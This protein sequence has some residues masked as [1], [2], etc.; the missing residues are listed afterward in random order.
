MKI[1]NQLPISPIEAFEDLYTCAEVINQVL[2]TDM[3]STK[4]KEKA[5]DR[6]CKL[7]ANYN[8]VFDEPVS[9]DDLS[10]LTSL[11]GTMHLSLESQKQ[12]T[13]PPSLIKVSI[14]ALQ[15]QALPTDEFPWSNATL[16]ESNALK[17]LNLYL[18]GKEYFQYKS[19][20]SLYNFKQLYHFALKN[21][22]VEIQ[23][24][25][26]KFFFEQVTRALRDTTPSSFEI[27]FIHLIP[28]F[29]QSSE[30]YQELLKIV[31][32][33][34][35]NEMQRS[36]MLSKDILYFKMCNY[37][38]PQLRNP[39]NQFLLPV[40]IKYLDLLS[41]GNATL[42]E[43]NQLYLNNDTFKITRA[44]LEI[45]IHESLFDCF[46]NIFVTISQS[47]LDAFREMVKELNVLANK[48][49]TINLLIR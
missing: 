10:M 43:Q 1:I 28:S 23:E 35:I 30:H 31:I 33:A 38:A 2:E 49:V 48:E 44:K 45:L 32:D 11:L 46:Q 12:A 40:L 34:C 8:K 41:P 26:K 36:M 24:N 22:L 7:S 6:I 42:D 19:H 18:E 25:L 9:A 29:T 47:D 14:Q 27:L 17:I 3:V 4:V 16:T 20:I 39:Q 13:Q 21:S 15:N 5:I 37:F